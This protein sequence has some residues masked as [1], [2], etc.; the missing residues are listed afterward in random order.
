MRVISLS[1]N[2]SLRGLSDSIFM[3]WV[4]PLPWNIQ[5]EQKRNMDKQRAWV[6]DVLPK[7]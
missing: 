1:W 3:D 7:L 2:G 5:L 4:A 6:N